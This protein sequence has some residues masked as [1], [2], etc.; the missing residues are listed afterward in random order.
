MNTIHRTNEK[1]S[2][3]TMAR[4]RYAQCWEDPRT[5]TQALKINPKD[6][7]VS[8]A[9]GG[10]NSFALLL[11]NPK[12]LAVVDFN[13]AQIF[14]VELKIR[15]IQKLDY[16]DF[17][18]FIGACACQNRLQLYS[19]LRSSLRDQAREY[20]DMETQSL[21]KGII[22]CGKFER[23]FSVFRQLVL[24]LIHHQKTV[25]RLLKTSSLKEQWTFY[26]EVWNNRR[27]QW[28]FHIFFGEF[29][30]G[31]L[32]RDPSFFQYVNLDNIAEELLR[33][34]RRGLTEISIQNNFFIEYILTG[35]YS[36][37]EKAHPYLRESNFDFLKEH[38]GRVCLVMGS[39][40]N[41]LSSLQPETISKLNLSDIFEYMSDD[42]FECL[43]HDILR[44]CRDDAKLA[45]WT[46]FIP[47]PVPSNFANCIDLCSS[48][49]EKLFAAARTFFY[50]SFGLWHVAR[51]GVFDWTN[52]KHTTSLFIK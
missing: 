23:Y 38:V 25:R 24:P 39:L 19:Y 18:G 2:E 43:L 46:L 41:Y 28:L 32:G 8:I 48:S 15:A 16:A 33:R 29:L 10:D 21:L 17:V 35:E 37:L 31:H 12:S 49:S 3:A 51:R 40:Q 1:R 52:Y 11:K 20:W 50:G 45:Y 47:R 26:D 27:W 14:L 13:P 22:H 42:D 36:H 5:L 6:D 44:V 30:L 9:S 4:I 7:V 34:T